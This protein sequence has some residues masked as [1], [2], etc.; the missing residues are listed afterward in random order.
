[1]YFTGSVVL[2][3][4]ANGEMVASVPLARQPAETARRRGQRHFH[5]AEHCFQNWLSCATC[6]PDARADGLNWDLQNDGLGNAK[7]TKSL[8]L[9][10]VTPPM[11]FTGVRQRISDAIAAGF[12]DLQFVLPDPTVERDVFAYLQSLRPRRSPHRRPDGE[13]SESAGRGETLFNSAQVGCA[14]CHVGQHTTDLKRYDVGTC[15]PHDRV[16]DAR[17]DTP[18]LAET[19]RAAPYLHDGRA[20][21][22]MEVLT[23]HNRDDRHGRTSHLSERELKDL[24][25][26]VLSQ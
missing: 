1:M 4:A 13:L 22:M 18:T 3:N 5:D 20:T 12:R 24:A 10:H 8:V 15:G 11:M 7:N 17:L 2:S 14:T 21:T 19:W 9:S 23:E 26:F 16:A 25:E 6:H